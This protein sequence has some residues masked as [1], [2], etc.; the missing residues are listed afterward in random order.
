MDA[1]FAILFVFLL[2]ELNELLEIEWLTRLYIDF[3]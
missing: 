3:V 1:H 2:G